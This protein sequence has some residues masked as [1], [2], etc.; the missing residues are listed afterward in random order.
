MGIGG[1]DKMNVTLKDVGFSIWKN[2]RLLIVAALLGGILAVGMT[3][4]V[5]KPTYT[6]TA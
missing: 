1:S 2:L 4:L 3:C 6:A 5:V